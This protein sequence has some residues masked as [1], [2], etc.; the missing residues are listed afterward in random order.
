MGLE[1]EGEA[2]EEVHPPSIFPKGRD[3]SVPFEGEAHHKQSNID[4]VPTTL[5]PAVGRRVREVSRLKWLLSTCAW[6]N[7]RQG[8]RESSCLVPPAVL[9]FCRSEKHN[10]EAT[11]QVLGCD[12]EREHCP[13]YRGQRCWEEQVAISSWETQIFSPA[14]GKAPRSQRPRWRYAIQAVT[15][16]L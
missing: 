13:V 10:A 9:W 14:L 6:S 4:I 7:V 16:P 3:P 1:F 8:G 5:G 2:V 15:V 12:K 11:R